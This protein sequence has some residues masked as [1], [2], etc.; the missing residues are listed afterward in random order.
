MSGSVWELP[1]SD[2]R[3]GSYRPGHDIHW[4][5]FKKA[6]FEPGERIPVTASVF[7]QPNEVSQVGVTPALMQ[8]MGAQR[9]EP[10]LLGVDMGGYWGVI[11]SPFGMCGGW[12][13][14]QSP[15]ARGYNDVSSVK[16]G[17]NILQYS[18]TH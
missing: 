1:S 15:Y 7:R 3:C 4:I 14:S 12:E 17:Q 8:D 10:Y 2:L 16:L 6:T 13:M 11:Y 18:V 5:H 9:S